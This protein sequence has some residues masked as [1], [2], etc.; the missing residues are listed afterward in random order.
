MYMCYFVIRMWEYGTQEL[1]SYA[2]RNANERLG[3]DYMINFLA[4]DP[5]STNVKRRPV[6]PAVHALFS[7]AIK[8]IPPHKR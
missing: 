4:K 2:G 1:A 3:Q 5:A 6:D 7:A 8:T